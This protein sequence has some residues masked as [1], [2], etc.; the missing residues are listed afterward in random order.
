[1]PELNNLN[2]LKS[3]IFDFDYTL[4]D[5]SRAV[6]MCA[7]YALRQM[8]FPVPS[9]EAVCRT[10]GLSLSASFQSLTGMADQGRVEEYCRLFIEKA[11]EVVLGNTVLFDS[12]RP[13][14]EALQKKGLDLG[15]VSTKF[16]YRI[17]AFLKREKIREAFPVIIGGEDV[18]LHKPDPGGLLMAACKL[19]AAPENILY[20]GDSTTDAETARRASVP[21]IAVLTGVTPARAFEP[22]S[23]FA[24][25]PSLEKLPGLLSS[26]Q[27]G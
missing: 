17:D 21:F 10:I 25:I 22:F 4:A 3:V 6:I 14:I 11:D 15:I 18:A 16:R 1:M 9:T 27:G 7:D 26:R 5:S 24:V 19:N 20:V 2:N 23:P 12:V 8:G 13:V